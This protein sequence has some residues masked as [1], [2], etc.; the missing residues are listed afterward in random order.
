MG[1]NKQKD[2]DVGGWKNTCGDSELVSQGS[3]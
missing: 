1:M 2:G 3:T